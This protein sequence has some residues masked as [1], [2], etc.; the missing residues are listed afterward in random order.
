MS[1]NKFIY[2]SNIYIYIYIYDLNIKNNCSN[3]CKFRV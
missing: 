3:L 1:K 2:I